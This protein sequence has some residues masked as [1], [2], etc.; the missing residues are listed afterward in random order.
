MSIFNSSGIPPRTSELLNLCAGNVNLFTAL[1]GPLLMAK[2]N[3]RTLMLLS[4]FFCAL[5]IFCFGFLSEYSVSNQ[6]M[7]DSAADS[8]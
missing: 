7:K 2:F 4:S 3:R 6:L 1:L 8:N 5:L